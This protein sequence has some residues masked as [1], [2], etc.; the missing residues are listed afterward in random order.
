MLWLLVFCTMAPLA[1]AFMTDSQTKNVNHVLEVSTLEG[2]DA[3]V[4]C[5]V[6][7]L[8]VLWGATEV[9]STGGSV[10]S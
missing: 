4:T 1:P 3:V 6:V 10:T 7:E 2:V 9:V 5:F 8:F